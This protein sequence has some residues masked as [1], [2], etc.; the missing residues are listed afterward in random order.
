LYLE[1]VGEAEGA[2][3]TEV[4]LFSTL[5]EAATAAV[6]A[7]KHGCRLEEFAET[8]THPE[9]DFLS[10]NPDRVWLEAERLIEIKTTGPPR[11]IR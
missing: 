7:H 6:Y 4:Q 5:F 1:K 3:E 9:H 8:L 2:P 11:P 10:A